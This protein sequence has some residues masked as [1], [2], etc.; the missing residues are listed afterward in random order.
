MI[1]G[2]GTRLNNEL[3]QLLNQVRALAL[4]ASFDIDCLA[5]PKIRACRASQSLHGGALLQ[6]TEAAGRARAPS[7]NFECLPGE[8]DPLGDRS[9]SIPRTG[10]H[11]QRPLLRLDVFDL[12]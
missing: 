1:D 8:P 3:L 2:D 12:T 4:S 11:P 6:P 7:T 9:S 10:T 5:A